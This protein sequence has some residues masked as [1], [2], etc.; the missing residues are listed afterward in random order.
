[1]FCVSGGDEVHGSG[2]RA[3]KLAFPK[4]LG[5]PQRHDVRTGRSGG[6]R[7]SLP[8]ALALLPG[9]RSL[10]AAGPALAQGTTPAALTS[11]SVENGDRRLILGWTAPRRAAERLRR[12]LHLRE[13]GNGGRRRTSSRPG[14]PGP[15][16]RAARGESRNRRCRESGRKAGAKLRARQAAGA[17]LTR[18]SP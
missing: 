6:R 10:L 7:F 12:A 5:A 8:P 18:S 14:S 13:G 15:R 3:R 1:M 2:T 4:S 9:A 17:K 16:V 11:L